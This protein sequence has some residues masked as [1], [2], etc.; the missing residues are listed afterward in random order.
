MAERKFKKSFDLHENWYLKV[1][2]IDL[3]LKVKIYEFQTAD[4]FNNRFLCKST[5]ISNIASISNSP[6]SQTKFLNSGY[7]FFYTQIKQVLE[8]PV[9]RSEP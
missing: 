3:K 9:C 7:G 8:S 6:F 2:K 4:P 5:N 1:F